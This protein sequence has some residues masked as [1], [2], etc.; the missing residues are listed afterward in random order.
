MD[1]GKLL[2]LGHYVQYC[3]DALENPL[4]ELG[5]P[6]AVLFRRPYADVPAGNVGHLGA[7]LGA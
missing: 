1:K 3:L 5:V 7:K 4:P 2:F 6:D